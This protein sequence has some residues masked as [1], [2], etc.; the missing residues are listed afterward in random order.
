MDTREGE[1][2][3]FPW[4]VFCRIVPKHFVE[5]PFRLSLFSGI[6]KFYAEE[7]YVTRFLRKFLS[8]SDK[9]FRRG[10]P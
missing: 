3:D 7:G 4:K 8:H 5:E 1:Y 6:D 10:I 9:N 2:Q